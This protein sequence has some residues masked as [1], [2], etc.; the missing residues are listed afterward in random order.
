LIDTAANVELESQTLALN[1][2]M[3]LFSEEG[4]ESEDSEPIRVKISV[5]CSL[6]S[7]HCD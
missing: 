7:R 6:I 1:L 5:S 3:K 2:A 4:F